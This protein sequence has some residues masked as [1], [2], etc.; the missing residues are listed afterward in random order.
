MRKFIIHTRPIPGSCRSS[1]PSIVEIEC[2]LITPMEDPSVMWAPPGEYKVRVL[3]PEFLHEPKEVSKPDDK[4]TLVKVKV[5][6][7]PIYYGHF[8]YDSA[9]EA[10]QAAVKLLRQESEF[11]VRKGGE[12]FTVEEMESKLSEIQEIRL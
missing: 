7:A 9:E 3:K 8:L 11:R 5:M 10:H 1:G 2:D 6:M 4:G 12:A